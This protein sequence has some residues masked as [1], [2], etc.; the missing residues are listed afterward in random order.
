MKRKSRMLGFTLVEMMVVIAVIAALLSIAAPQ[1][2][3][4]LEEG[5]KAKCV[6]NRYHIEQDERT[7]YL[8]SNRTSLA[9]DGRYLCASGGTY[10]WLVNDPA[11]PEYPRVGCSLHYGQTPAA[12]TSLGSTFSEITTAMIDLITRYV[13]QNN[14]YPR[15][16][17]T[18]AFTDLGLNP[19]EWTQ[20][21]TGLLYT[22][23]G[24]QVIV[25]PATGYTMTMKTTRGATVTLTPALNWNLLYDVPTGQWYYKQKE[26]KNVVNIS[27]LQVIKN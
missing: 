2:A 23:A 4:Y 18:R 6:A 17:G 25:E 12:L 11:A 7:Y 10:A 15:S 1:L 20:P 21:V 13:Q 22:P 16:S 26:D 24:E 27:T 9:I 5:R 8:N 19:A 14:R 3:A